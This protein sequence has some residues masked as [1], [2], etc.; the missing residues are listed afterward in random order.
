MADLTPNDEALVAS[1]AAAA[2]GNDKTLYLSKVL[3]RI[4]L[5]WRNLKVRSTRSRRLLG[6]RNQTE[7]LELS[8]RSIL[9]IA[10]LR[11]RYTTL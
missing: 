6:V 4:P 8:P 2:A 9:S 3:H 1:P 5:F 11:T 7:Y 10:L